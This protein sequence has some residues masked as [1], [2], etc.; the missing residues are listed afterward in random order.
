MTVKSINWEYLSRQE[1]YCAKKVARFLYPEGCERKTFNRGK[2]VLRSLLYR[3]SLSRVFSLFQCDSLKALPA[4]YPELLDKPM[5]PYRFA[6]STVNQRVK[7]VEDHYRLLLGLYPE[8]IDPLYLGEGIELGRYPEG[9]GRL[10]LRHDGTF[11]REAELALSIVNEQGERLYSCAFS[12]AGNEQELA[13]VIGSVQGPEPCV[14][15]PQEQ[16]RALTRA[17]QGLRPKSLVVMLVMALAGAMGASRVSAVRMKAHI[18]QARRY[19]KKKKACLQADYDELWQEF[20]ALD[21]DANFVRLQPVVRKPLEEVA[22]KKRAMYRR[23]YA[24]LD[25]LTLNCQQA[26]NCTPD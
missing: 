3:K 8:L 15:Q 26:L 24:W 12:L 7:M 9:G 23:R 14:E 6:C 22:A 25:E 11:R 2:F 5:R 1:R 21:Q 20:G 13:L 19:S 10:V 18:F 4:V 17:G 16:V